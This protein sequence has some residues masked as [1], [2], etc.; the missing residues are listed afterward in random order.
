MRITALALAALAYLIPL[1][2]QVML[3]SGSGEVTD[4]MFSF[5]TS[6][7]T[8]V[9][10]FGLSGIASALLIASRRDLSQPT[11][12]T[13]ALTRIELVLVAAPALIATLLVLAV[14]VSVAAA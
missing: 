8:L 12:G 2:W 7:G 5:V 4:G 1:G 14:L 10:A 13:S 6:A 3:R 11:L 9:L